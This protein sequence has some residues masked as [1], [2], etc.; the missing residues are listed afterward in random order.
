VLTVRCTAK[1]L[2]RLRGEPVA[3]PAPSTTRLGEWY[4]TI[5]AMRPFH[6]VL[7]VNETTRLPVYFPAKPLAT[8]GQRIPDAIAR[9]LFELGIDPEVIAEERR[10]MEPVVFAKTASRSVLGTMNQFIFELPYILDDNVSMTDLEL[11]MKLARGI[12]TIPPLSY[13]VPAEQV[14]LALARPA[15]PSRS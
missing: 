10:A 11:S 5:L 9:V 1:L 13:E 12:T 14:V 4:A 6:V 15:P 8:L 2:K 3:E 7:L